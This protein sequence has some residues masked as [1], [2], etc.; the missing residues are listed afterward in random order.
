[1][2]VFRSAHKKTKKENHMGLNVGVRVLISPNEA[3]LDCRCKVCNALRSNKS[4]FGMVVEDMKD[5]CMVL[6]EGQGYPVGIKKAN[7]SVAQ[8]KKVERKISWV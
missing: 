3:R 2:G 5:H 4:V 7:L 1:M 8:T 6:I